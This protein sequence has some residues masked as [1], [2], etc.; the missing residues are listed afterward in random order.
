[1]SR[2]FK[3]ILRTKI[4]APACHCTKKIEIKLFNFHSKQ[5]FALYHLSIFLFSQNLCSLIHNFVFCALLLWPGIVRL[6]YL[7]IEILGRFYKQ[8]IRLKFFNYLSSNIHP[9]SDIC[10]NIKFHRR[11]FLI[12]FQISF[13]T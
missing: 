9:S 7:E 6:N 1:M 4:T 11:H 3:I 8:R 12:R 2:N 10:T 5:V 13:S